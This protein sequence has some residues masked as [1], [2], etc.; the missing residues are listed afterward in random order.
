[1]STVTS[2]AGSLPIWYTRPGTSVTKPPSEYSTSSD[3]DT[4]WMVL[5]QFGRPHDH[6]DTGWTLAEEGDRRRVWSLVLRH[7]RHGLLVQ[8]VI[9][10][11][12]RL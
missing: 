9:N 5:Q 10:G 8:A 12:S 11:Y 2:A 3:P 4:L 6:P 1:M 7:Q